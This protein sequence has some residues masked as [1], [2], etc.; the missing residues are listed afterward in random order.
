MG[1]CCL[2]TC[3][4]ELGAGAGGVRGVIVRG[5]GGWGAERT[6]RAA[7]HE[8]LASLPRRLRVTQRLHLPLEALNLLLGLLKLLLS[9]HGH[10]ACRRAGGQAGNGGAVRTLRRTRP[11][12]QEAA[13]AQAQAQ[14]QSRPRVCLE[15]RRDEAAAAGRRRVAGAGFEARVVRHEDKA[16]PDVSGAKRWLWTALLEALARARWLGRAGRR[17]SAAKEAD[18]NQ[19]AWV[20]T[21]V[22]IQ[23]DLGRC[24]APRLASR[25]FGAAWP[26]S[27]RPSAAR[28]RH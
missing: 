21:P 22:W 1:S 9:L 10:G 14:R 4:M 11:L 3:S 12:V 2:V 6:A 17:S 28:R 26:A 16:P 27:A 8:R 7:D 15:R 18:R 13:V 5:R 20:W 23:N 25:T 19:R 24:G